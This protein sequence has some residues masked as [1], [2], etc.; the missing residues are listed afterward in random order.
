[1]GARRGRERLSY[2]LCVLQILIFLN[3][4]VTAKTSFGAFCPETRF[5]RETWAK[6]SISMSELIINFA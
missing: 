4:S 5:C 3:P 2:G 6:F 1:M